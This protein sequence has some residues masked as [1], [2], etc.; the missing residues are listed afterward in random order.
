[1]K[2]LRLKSHCWFVA[3]QGSKAPLIFVTLSSTIPGPLPEGGIEKYQVVG[4]GK[5]NDEGKSVPPGKAQ[6]GR[7]WLVGQVDGA[8]FPAMSAASQ[9]RC[10]LQA[11][12]LWALQVFPSKAAASGAQEKSYCRP[13]HRS[14]ATREE[15][16]KEEGIRTGQPGRPWVR[17]LC[18]PW[19]SRTAPGSL[20]SRHFILAK[21]MGRL[22]PEG[23]E[24]HGRWTGCIPT[25][26]SRQQA[27][28]WGGGQEPRGPAAVTTSQAS[29]WPWGLAK[30]NQTAFSDWKEKE[31]L[32]VGEIPACATFLFPDSPNIR[33]G[34][35]F[36][37]SANR[38]FSFCSGGQ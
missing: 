35:G 26:P 27:G 12:G 29:F 7:G 5:K 36:P 14:P 33:A 17:S 9:G 15:G 21:G 3:G 2:N 18:R 30:G 28:Q 22:G 4:K 10:W 16:E 11:E 6:G 1:M 34:R 25:H 37:R 8:S 38:T 32:Q 23:A 31:S 20:G 13:H 19:S 24:S